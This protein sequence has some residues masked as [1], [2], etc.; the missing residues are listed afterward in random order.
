MAPFVAKLM[1]RSPATSKSVARVIL[2]TLRRKRPPLRVPA[3]P[4]AWMFAG[5]RRV[6]PRGMYHWLLY[7]SLPHV[8]AWGREGPGPQ[9]E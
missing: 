4:D 8:K 1:N 3:T 6:L 2:R 9:E 7:R 5:L